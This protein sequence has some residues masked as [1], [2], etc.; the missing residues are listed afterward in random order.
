MDDRVGGPTSTCIDGL[1]PAL[2]LAGDHV[3]R[4]IEHTFDAW[5][6]DA[7]LCDC[8]QDSAGKS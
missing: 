8:R 7:A 6:A 1:V 4:S 3:G 5:W 2:I